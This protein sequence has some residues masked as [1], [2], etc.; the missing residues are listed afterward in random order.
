MGG[1]GVL[2]KLNQALYQ[3]VYGAK[4]AGKPYQYM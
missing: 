4:E 1:K 2:D 3:R